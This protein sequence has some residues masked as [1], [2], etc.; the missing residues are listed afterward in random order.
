MNPIRAFKGGYDFFLNQFKFKNILRRGGAIH[1]YDFYKF[2]VIKS[3]HL[4]RKP[5]L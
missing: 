1:E 3:F 4:I 2:Y 5:N